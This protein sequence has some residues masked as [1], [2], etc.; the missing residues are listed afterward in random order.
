MHAA[1]RH[2]GPGFGGVLAIGLQNP[3][4]RSF[5]EHSGGHLVAEGMA[6]AL[7][8][9]FSFV[10]RNALADP[11][12]AESGRRFFEENFEIADPASAGGV[13]YYRGRFL[14]RT[15]R[16]D[17]LNVLLEFC[18]EPERMF[19]EM[20]W[21]RCLD[22]A[23][24]VRAT[25]MGEGPARRLEPTVDLIIRFKDAEAILGVMGR[26]GGIDVV[27]LLLENQVQLTGNTGHLFKL[28]AIGANVQHALGL[29]A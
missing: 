25:A 13:R 9:G 17:D 12:G 28:G 11:E 24:V 5:L 4:F 21:G 3:A 6:L 18:P 27:G 29:P 16:D 22:P 20:P 1:I 14:I 2:L 26:P 15:E 7:E 23:K 8:L 19:V 10:M